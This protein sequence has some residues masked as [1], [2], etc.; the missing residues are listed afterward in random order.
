MKDNTSMPLDFIANG[1]YI[2][3]MLLRYFSAVNF[4]N[5]TV[6]KTR[7]IIKCLRQIGRWEGEKDKY[8]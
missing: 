2:V 8:A 5:Q 6:V 7:A 4:Y 1:I 3:I